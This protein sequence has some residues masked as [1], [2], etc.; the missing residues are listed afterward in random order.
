MNAS[1]IAG[2]ALAAALLA[3]TLKK[4]NPEWAGA[5]TIGAGILFF[6]MVLRGL[7]PVLIEAEQLLLCSGANEEMIRIL[8]KCLGTCLLVQFSADCCR[9]AGEN[10]LAGR[11][12][13]AGKATVV[14][15]SLPLFQQILSLAL[16]LLG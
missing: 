12:E 11:V 8:L 2:T 10:A 13:F 9:D 4:N 14:T 5:L 6:M 15:L 16:S 1:V 7:T 3:Q